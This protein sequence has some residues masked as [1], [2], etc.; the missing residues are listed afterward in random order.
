M[1]I[2]DWLMIVAVLTGPVLAVQAQKWI[3]KSRE[4]RVRKLWILDTLMATRRTRLV[5]EHVRALNMI[6]LAFK[7]KTDKKVKTAWKAYLDHLYQPFEKDGL[8]DWH[9]K[10]E[11]YFTGLLYEMSQAL[12]YDFDKTYL[13]RSIYAPKA[14]DE[15]ELASLAIR[16]NLVR[17]L[18]GEKSLPITITSAETPELQNEMKENLKKFMSGL[19]V[20]KVELVRGQSEE[21][22]AGHTS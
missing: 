1:T 8:K 12:G 22:E 18:I 16:D 21:N 6:D 4:K 7:G 5:Q 17:I 13:K 15:Q 2:Q 9:S 14:Y 11:E 19:T 10:G 20:V 3:E